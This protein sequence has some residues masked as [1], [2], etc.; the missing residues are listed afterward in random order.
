MCLEEVQA[1][2]QAR[3]K[4]SKYFSSLQISKGISLQG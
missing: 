3:L 1:G 4:S 2:D